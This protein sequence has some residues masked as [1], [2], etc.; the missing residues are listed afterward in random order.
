MLFYISFYFFSG[1]QHTTCPVS[2]AFIKLVASQYF[3]FKYFPT[4]KHETRREIK[5]QYTQKLSYFSKSSMT[6]CCSYSV[7][8]TYRST[9]GLRI[10]SQ[11]IH[12]P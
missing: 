3:F 1:P 6:S 5:S 8:I 7:F 2:G 9:W 12:S 11:M 4:Q 10:W